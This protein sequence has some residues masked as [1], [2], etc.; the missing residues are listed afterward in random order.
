MVFVVG[1]PVF[2][3]RNVLLGIFTQYRTFWLFTNAFAEL[4]EVHAEFA[5]CGFSMFPSSHEFAMVPLE[6]KNSALFKLQV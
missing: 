3:G 4:L 2:A 6:K 1:V 5:A